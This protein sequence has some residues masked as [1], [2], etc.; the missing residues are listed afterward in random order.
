M[1]ARAVFC[2]VGAVDLRN[3]IANR[4]SIDLPATIIY[5]YPSPAALAVYLVAQLAIKSA[6]STD[7]I[8]TAAELDN[9]TETMPEQYSLLSMAD[10]QSDLSTEVIGMSIRYPGQYIGTQ[11]TSN[12]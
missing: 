5:D 8:T 10:R 12:L 3:A 7:S 2:S 4:Y 1:P 11:C 6:S 9:L